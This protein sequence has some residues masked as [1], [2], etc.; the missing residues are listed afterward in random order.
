MLMDALNF[1]NNAMVGWSR[2]FIDSCKVETIFTAL[3][4][5]G[6]VPTAT[7]ISNQDLTNF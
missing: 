4:A 3:V 5:N 1:I 6:I 2:E 7:H